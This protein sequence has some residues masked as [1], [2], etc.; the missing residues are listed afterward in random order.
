[1]T[2][3]SLFSRAVLLTIQGKFNSAEALCR[4]SLDNGKPVLGLDHVLSLSAANV[5]ELYILVQGKVNEADPML[6]YDLLVRRRNLYGAN[7]ESTLFTMKQYATALFGRQKYSESEAIWREMIDQIETF[8][9]KN[10]DNIIEAR[11]WLGTALIAQ[12]GTI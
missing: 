6:L 12:A 4:R 2:I 11:G 7:H 10:K 8:E 1:M 9:G 3:R 5:L